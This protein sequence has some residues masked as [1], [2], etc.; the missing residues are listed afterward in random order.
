ML[1]SYSSVVGDVLLVYF[2]GIIVFRILICCFVS[3]LAS[4]SRSVSECFFAV[5]MSFAS[6]FL[7][8]VCRFLFSNV[9]FCIHC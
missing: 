7:Y 4:A 2:F 5:L 8:C 9:G 6:F 1:F 3:R